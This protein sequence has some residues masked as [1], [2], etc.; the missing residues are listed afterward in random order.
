M[1]IRVLLAD[2]HTMFRQG[3][4]HVLQA[5]EGIEVVGEAM[6][7]EMACQLVSELRPDVLLLDVHMPKMD[8]VRATRAIMQGPKPPA[9]IILTMS[10][11]DDYVFEAIKAGARGYYT[12]DSDVSLLLRA[13]EQAALG[14]VLLDPSMTQRVLQTFRQL[15]S[16]RAANV[17]VAA[18]E[19]RE[20]DILR[21]V[22]AG[23]S[24]QE[25][26]VALG[27]SEKTIKNQ[28]SFIF[29]K[30]NLNNRTQAAIYSLQHG[31]ISLEEL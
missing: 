16:S 6:D 25:I 28:L 24:N 26:G 14:E 8:G 9:I 3:I 29:Q 18:L 31:L 17:G 2:D 27:L 5:Q 21:R 7:G 10:K 13:V 23:D 15:P 12:K 1:A 30:L 19:D 22:A 11:Q 4:R 20:I